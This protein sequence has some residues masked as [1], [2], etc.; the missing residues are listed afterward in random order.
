M[1]CFFDYVPFANFLF[2]SLIS[3]LCG[4]TYGEQVPIAGPETGSTRVAIVGTSCLLTCHHILSAMA[5]RLLNLLLVHIGAGAAGASA[6][7][8]LRKHVDDSTI[9]VDIT[10]F[11]RSPRVG[12][13]TATV[14]AFDDPAIPVELGASIFVEVNEILMNA[15]DEFGLST[16]S[17]DLGRPKEAEDSLGV[18]DGTEFVYRHKDNGYYW[19]DIAK[20]LWKYGMS[21]IRTQ[22]LMKAT[23]GK[24]RE[25]YRQPHF[26]WKS[27][28]AAAADTGLVDATSAT[29]SEFLK[30]HSI[31]DGF[32]RDIIQ[33]STRVNYGQ[34]LPLIHGLE[35]M[36]CMAAEGA[37][38]VQGGNWQIFDSM[39]KASRAEMRMNSTVAEIN[40]N[41]NRTYTISYLSEDG[42]EQHIFDHVILASPFQ[43][44]DIEISP[45][46]K[47]TPDTIP[48]V[49]LHV[50]LF[51]SPRQ[52]SPRFFNL[53][54]EAS[55]PE[56]ILTTLPSNV[57]LGADK[58][59]V[60]PAGFWSIS[61][62]KKVNPLKEENA[63]HQTSQPH[64]I[65][66]IFSPE[67]V[68]ADFMVDLLGIED[69]HDRMRNNATSGRIADIP[70][71]YIGWYHEKIWNSYPY[72]YPRVTFEEVELGQNLWYTSGIESFISTMETSALSGMN[73]AG[74]VFNRLAKDFGL[75]SDSWNWEKVEL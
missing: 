29:G 43:F 32:S 2:P 74:L 55:V 37:V 8:Y 39:L 44:S 23:V 11:E 20:L 17:A 68:T 9:P 45:S 13:R 40:Q 12:G 33:A 59:G 25:M 18:W 34:N 7:Y 50:T 65:Y 63:E 30:G 35:T 72:L 66:K 49:Q 24:F 52:L 58:A 67:P 47:Q 60:G 5:Y 3:P 70:T 69:Q 42:T 21:P 48:Y 57:D 64:Y 22:N 16:R 19:W 38:G 41:D 75:S 62:L 27:L 31:S 51:A 4:V 46:P 1:R 71:K 14:N 15:T 73:A 26:P 10:V 6:A 53:S 61:T 56:T 28:S 54:P 36:V